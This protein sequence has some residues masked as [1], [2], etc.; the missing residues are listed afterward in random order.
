HARSNQ[1][2]APLN[3]DDSAEVIKMPDPIIEPITIIVASIG[4]R[5]R[6]KLALLSIFSF[7]FF[8]SSR[9]ETSLTVLR[10]RIFRDISA[11]ELLLLVSQDAPVTPVQIL[12]IPVCH[13][14]RKLSP[15][16][17]Q[18][19]HC[20]SIELSPPEAF[21]L[22]VRPILLDRASK[23]PAD[24]LE[25]ANHPPDNCDPRKLRGRPANAPLRQLAQAHSCR[26]QIKPVTNRPKR[27][28]ALLPRQVSHRELPYC[29]ARR[30]VSHDSAA[31]RYR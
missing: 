23:H 10:V 6:S 20:R 17:P 30:A 12:P 27:L 18:H 15:R 26:A 5:A 24:F 19:R 4:P 8:K 28:R 13:R 3:R 2:G 31:R 11:L 7:I 22:R 29:R 9:V 25:Q 14:G 1:P 21:A 16:E